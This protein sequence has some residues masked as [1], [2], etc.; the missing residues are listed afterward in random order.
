MYKRKVSET[1]KKIVAASQG[2]HCNMCKEM[3]TAFYECDHV[4]A[5]WRGGSNETDNLQALCR[6]CHAKKGAAE[7]LAHKPDVAVSHRAA[8][9]SGGALRVT[10]MFSALFEPFAG[11]AFPL[12]V[13][14]RLCV[15]RFGTAFDERLVAV[16]VA[17]HMVFPPHWASLFVQAGMVPQ[18]EGAVLQSV[19]LRKGNRIISTR[20][21]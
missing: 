2:W 20:S 17:P 4:V 12:A 7:R 6:N 13:A 5:L 16:D 15:I 10:D 11:G 8:A 1:T 3:L 9:A 18:R 19:R 21:L 14:K